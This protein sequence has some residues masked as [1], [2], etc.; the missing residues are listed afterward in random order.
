MQ[1]VFAVAKLHDNRLSCNLSKTRVTKEGRNCLACP[2]TLVSGAGEGQRPPAHWSTGAGGHRVV[3]GTFQLRLTM[4]VPE[5]EEG[6]TLG[7]EQQETRF[8][9][10]LRERCIIW[11]VRAHPPQTQEFLSETSLNLVPSSGS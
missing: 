1:Q 10:L 5:Y 6:T 8:R 3:A 2:S 4:D 11:R 9:I 7:L